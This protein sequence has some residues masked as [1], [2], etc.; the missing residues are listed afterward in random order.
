MFSNALRAFLLSHDSLKDLISTR[1]YPSVAPEGTV[2][3]YVCYYEV[4]GVSWHDIPVAYPRFQ[5][6]VFATR[7]L[8]AKNVAI[9][10]RNILQ[11]YKGDMGGYRVIQIVWEGSR[12]LYEPDNKLHHI[13]TDFRII[14][15][16]V[17]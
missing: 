6:S 11:R 15:R 9:E 8:D 17:D 3:P 5:F 7:Y 12:E 14:Y 13:A 4:S 2:Q 16:E 1:L 10:I